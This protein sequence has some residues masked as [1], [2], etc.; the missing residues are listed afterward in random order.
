MKV[1]A[2][3]HNNSMLKFARFCE[4]FTGSWIECWSDIFCFVI[5]AFCL[6]TL[7]YAAFLI[8]L[9]FFFYL[10][11]SQFVVNG[12]TALLTKYFGGFLVK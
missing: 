12:K 4:H 8:Y 7:K 1:G 10:E 9:V 11:N 3:N 6:N 5:F 2:R